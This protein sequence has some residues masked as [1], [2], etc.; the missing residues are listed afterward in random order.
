VYKSLL[1]KK[2]MARKEKIGVWGRCPSGINEGHVTETWLPGSS[3]VLYSIMFWN[4]VFTVLIF[5]NT[6]NPPQAF[7]FFFKQSIISPPCCSGKT[8]DISLD[9][10]GVAGYKESPGIEKQRADDAIAWVT[11]LLISA[12]QGIE[13]DLCAEKSS[14]HW[15]SKQAAPKLGFYWIISNE[16]EEADV[17]SQRGKKRQGYSS[18]RNYA[19]CICARLHNNAFPFHIYLEHAIYFKVYVLVHSLSAWEK[20][21]IPVNVIM[22]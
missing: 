9:S 2:D 4:S 19:W 3:W 20:M 15:H 7:L 17:S 5:G 14:N 16:G 10:G 22:K 6:T 21:T 1:K 12:Q 8:T 13:W 18:E 11:S